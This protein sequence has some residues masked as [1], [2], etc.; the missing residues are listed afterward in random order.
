MKNRLIPFA[1]ALRRNQTDAEAKVWAVL[2]NRQI[3]GLKFRRQHP[4]GR[5][6][7]DFCCEEV[8]LIIELD[9]GQHSDRAL[10]DHERTMVIEDM[11]YIVLR[12]WNVDIFEAL[13]GVVDQILAAARAARD[14]KH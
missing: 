2:R 11:K 3:E 10:Q 6:V 8:G 12:F 13:D 4:I 14:T 1:R 9:G 5:Y 7:A